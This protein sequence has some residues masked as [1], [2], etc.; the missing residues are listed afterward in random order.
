M[1]SLDFYH[2]LPPM[3]DFNAIADEN[4]Y[5]A[6]PEDWTVVITDIK[7]ST[8][9]IEMGRY[10]D[11]NT[12]G[13][14][15]IAAAQNALQREFPFV[16][17][18]D[19]ATL[20]IP[21]EDIPK[22]KAALLG[23]QNLSTDNFQLTLRIGLVKVREL[24]QA[25][26][27]LKIAR[28]ELAAGK[29]IA[30]F[31]GGGLQAAEDKIKNEPHK[32]NIH[33]NEETQADLEGLSCRWN[34]IPNKNGLVLSI[35]VTARGEQKQATYLRVIQELEKILGD[36]LDHFNPVNIQQ[37]S[38]KT[39]WD[40]I[41][42]E[43]KLAP[44]PWHYSFLWRAFEILV[45]ALLFQLRLGQYLMPMKHYEEAMQTHSDYRKFDEMLRMVID[46]S[47]VQKDHIR[48]YFESEQALGNI[49]FGT[50][51]SKNSLMTCYVNTVNDG[52]HIHFIDGDNGGYAIA[53]KEMKSQMAL[54][55]AA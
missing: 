36:K 4:Q 32:Y 31:Y 12:I 3:P 40:N 52:D 2:H 27:Q 6:V 44:H 1:S 15:T 19:G 42:S 8:T 48:E 16:F 45:C 33:A 51:C 49:Y 28:H 47:E 14:A 10:R 35:L 20:V 25:G 29:C 13:A 43:K 5:Q 53:A 54:V 46:C 37:A 17:G 30:M 22:I 21:N 41:N 9:A 24:Y 18:G 55:K 7:G 34:P 50:H 26:H 39:V 11:V 23:V 38:Y